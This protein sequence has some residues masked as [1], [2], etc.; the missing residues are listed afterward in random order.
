MSE[1]L[2]SR[3]AGQAVPRNDVLTNKCLLMASVGLTKMRASVGLKRGSSFLSSLFAYFFEN[4]K[5]K[6]KK[7]KKFVDWGEE[8]KEKIIIGVTD[9]KVANFYY[10]FSQ[11]TLALRCLT[12]ARAKFWISNPNQPSLIFLNIYF[13]KHIF[14]FHESFPQFID[15][16]FY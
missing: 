8:K 12:L 10:L 13:L 14:L 3:L 11:V 7:E 1:I 4:E 5:S 15:I 9:N 2:L 6:K 16:Y